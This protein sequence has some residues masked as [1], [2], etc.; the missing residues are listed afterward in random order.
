MSAERSHYEILNITREAPDFLI[1]AAYKSLSQKYHPDV[2]PDDPDANATMAAIN[3]AYQTLSDAQKRKSYDQWLDKQIVRR[4]EPFGT[5]RS[6]E[7]SFKTAKKSRPRKRIT[8]RSLLGAIINF[9]FLA[10]I[11]LFVLDDPQIAEMR[12]DLMDVVK[13]SMR[14]A[15]APSAQEEVPLTSPVSTGFLKGYRQ[16]TLDGPNLILVSNAAN[17]FDAEARLV[18]LQD[19]STNILRFFYVKSGETIE[20]EGLGNSYY[21]VRFRQRGSDQYFYKPIDL[22]RMKNR[23]MRSAPGAARFVDLGQANRLSEAEYFLPDADAQILEEQPVL[24]RLL[25]QLSDPRVRFAPNGQPWPPRSG[26]VNGYRQIRTN[27]EH[28]IIIQNND[29]A[30]ALFVML[31]MGSQDRM[32]AVRTLYLKPSSELMIEELEAG[33]YQIKLQFVTSDEAFVTDGFSVGSTRA[34]SAGR[35]KP[36]VIRL[37][38]LQWTAIPALY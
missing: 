31:E 10:L 37:N 23:S 4:T 17:N 16:Q 26:L 22:S 38:S 20:I 13:A 18:S 7:N 29:S 8:I 3:Y 36:E 15:S 9:I 12:G 25:N 35:L 24:K 30:N 19:D 33:G 2:N 34:S 11:T 5:R 32:T 1:R 6:T 28:A 27:G 14:S 21:E